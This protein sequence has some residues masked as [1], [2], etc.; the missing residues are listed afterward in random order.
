MKKIKSKKVILIS[1]SIF[2]VLFTLMIIYLFTPQ[3]THKNCEVCE[4]L[5]VVSDIS[6]AVMSYIGESEDMELRLNTSKTV[7]V[8]ELLSGFYNIIE[9]KGQKYGPYLDIE[10]KKA[11][12]LLEGKK[13]KII[14]DETEEDVYVETKISDKDEIIIKK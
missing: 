9:Y 2:V 13:L 4:M 14:I 1:I 10:D 11:K 8:T 6:T 5:S 3:V 7:T 12:K